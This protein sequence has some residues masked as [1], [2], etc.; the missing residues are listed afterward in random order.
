M[1]K[2]SSLSPAAIETLAIIAY[3]QPITRIEIE[4]IRGVGCEMML[5]KLLIRN[6]IR[7]IGRSDAP[8]KPILY[9]VTNEFMDV[10][11]LVSLK[12]LPDLPSYENLHD[13]ENLFDL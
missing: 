5:R 10:F 11:K 3:K 1:N 4:E 9:E 13:G 8:G 12:E 7:E 6:L 2:S